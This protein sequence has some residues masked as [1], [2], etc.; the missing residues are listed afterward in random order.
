MVC[1][2]MCL[3][4][5]AGPSDYQVGEKHATFEIGSNMTT[6]EYSTVEDG[7]REDNE[8]FSAELIIPLDLQAMM[9]FAGAP[10][11]AMVHIVD[12]E[13]ECMFDVCTESA[14]GLLN[15]KQCSLAY[16]P[17]IFGLVYS[18]THC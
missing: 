3:S 15:R 1:T 5:A 11:T 17:V 2:R 10:D 7:I 14:R 4:F 6:V 9:I 8:T 16:R 13:G 12:D 18:Y